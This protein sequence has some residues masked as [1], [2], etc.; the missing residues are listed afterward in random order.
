MILDTESQ[1]CNKLQ[2]TADWKECVLNIYYIVFSALK[3]TAEK[4]TAEFSWVVGQI[5]GSQSWFMGQSR[6]LKVW[7]QQMK[8]TGI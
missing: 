7:T 6:W 4:Q 3:Q 2:Q 5:T 8:D 1:Q